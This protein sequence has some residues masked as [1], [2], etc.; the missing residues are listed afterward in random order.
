MSLPLAITAA[1]AASAKTLEET[2]VLDVG[3]L[4]A[5]TDHFVITGGRNDRQVR[6][7]VDEVQRQVKA[8]GGRL[9]RSEGLDA[10]HWVLLDYGDFVVHVLD[11]EARDYYGLERLWADSPRVAWE[12]ASDAPR[13]PAAHR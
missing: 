9:L 13:A 10:G 12:D 8:A 4:I 5:L 2:V 6:A 7:V 11:A 3:E 1:R